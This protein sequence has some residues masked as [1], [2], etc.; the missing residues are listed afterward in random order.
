MSP[1]CPDSL[2]GRGC[3]HV[4]SSH[5]AQAFAFAKG[6]FSARALAVSL[7]VGVMVVS[8]RLR[9]VRQQ[10]EEGAVAYFTFGSAAAHGRGKVKIMI[11]HSAT[12][13][14]PIA[15]SLLLDALA[16][17]EKRAA[18][19]SVVDRG[20][21][22][23]NGCSEVALWFTDTASKV[24]GGCSSS[25]NDVLAPVLSPVDVADLA[26]LVGDTIAV[27]RHAPSGLPLQRVSPPDLTGSLSPLSTK[28]SA[29]S[30]FRGIVDE[31]AESHAIVEPS[32]RVVLKSCLKPPSM[33]C[34]EDVPVHVLHNMMMAA[35]DTLKSRRA[36][37]D[38]LKA[39]S[40]EL[41]PTTLG[42]KLAIA[43]E[44]AND[45]NNVA[46]AATERWH[47]A[48]LRADGADG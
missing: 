42:L 4:N 40:L 25:C 29:P 17:V 31:T 8:A 16:S 30:S 1:D 22:H 41:D 19:S 27:G 44:A 10:V 46:N 32:V 18:V 13:T 48:F 14:S 21:K 7:A 43:D 3:C 37:Y 34:L 15:R 9:W 35:E 11:Q 12:R 45:A 28:G 23:S 6:F 20:H 39:N 33:S 26:P 47:A 24:N 38:S 2:H 36:A 5:F